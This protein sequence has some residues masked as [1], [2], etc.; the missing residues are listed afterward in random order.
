MLVLRI[1]E[2]SGKWVI[3]PFETHT[4]LFEGRIYTL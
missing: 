3:R 2:K 4:R 1:G